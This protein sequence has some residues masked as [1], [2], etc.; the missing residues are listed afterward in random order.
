MG[1]SSDLLDGLTEQTRDRALDLVAYAASL[2]LT[3]SQSP[4][5]PSF[6]LTRDRP[7]ATHSEL[8]SVW[9]L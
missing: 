1:L 3:P 4:H 7:R 8:W 6:S 5:S 2:T 9:T